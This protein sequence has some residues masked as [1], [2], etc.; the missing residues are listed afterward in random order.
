MIDW[1]IAFG[2]VILVILINSKIQNGENMIEA[3]TWTLI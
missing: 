1:L 3:Y 2:Q